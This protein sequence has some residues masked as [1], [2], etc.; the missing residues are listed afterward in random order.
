LKGIDFIG[1][2]HGEYDHL[3]NLLTK[4]GY[5]S[6]SR[7]WRHP[8]G[9]KVCFLGDY[10][11]RGPKI[12]EVLQTVRGMV[13]SGDAFAIM[14]NHEFNFIAWHTPLTDGST[15]RC[16][17]EHKRYQMEESLLQLGDSP[18]EWAEWMR[19]LPASWEIK[20][21]RA[22]HACWFKED[23]E[24]LMKEWVTAGNYWTETLIR[25]SS[26]GAPLFDVVERVMKGPELTLPSGVTIELGKGDVR[27]DARIQWWYP[28]DTTMDLGLQIIPRKD[29]LGVKLTLDQS[30][31]WPKTLSR[32]D[33]IVFCGHYWLRAETPEPRSEKVVCLDYSV[34]KKGFLCA[35]RYD[36]ETVATADKMVASV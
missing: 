10:V 30:K 13:D 7:S 21:A 8:Q 11:D 18:G 17:P 28:P 3:I 19:T 2:I 29:P 27:T 22:V 20:G 26:P 15:E 24:L 31:A 35:Y 5:I 14:G 23:V 12:L 25:R 4:L 16:R 32:D 6:N 33:S 36:G 34:A 1:D 9:R